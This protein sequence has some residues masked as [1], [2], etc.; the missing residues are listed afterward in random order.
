MNYSEKLKVVYQQLSLDQ[1]AVKYYSQRFY[2]ELLKSLAGEES[3]LK[4]APSFLGKPNGCETG[5]FMAID[6]GGSNIRVYLI[7]LL[8]SGKYQIIRNVSR[9]LKD[10]QGNYDYTSAAVHAPELF[11]FI[12]S[13]AAQIT[14]PDDE[15]CL[16]HTFSFPTKQQSVRDAE[17]LRWTKEIKTSGVNKPINS[18]LSESL[19]RNNLP[20]IKPVALINDTVATLLAQAYQNNN[21][22]IGSIC[23]TGHNTCYFESKLPE[24]QPMIINLESGNFNKLP[25]SVFDESLDKASDSPG[26]QRFEKMLSGKYIGEVLRIITQYIL[27]PADSIAGY[28]GVLEPYSLKAEHISAFLSDDSPDLN[29]IADILNTLGWDVSL[30]ERKLINHAA[31]LLIKRSTKLL[32]ASYSAIIN[33]IDPGLSKPH[34]IAVDGSLFR[35]M[36]GY[37]AQIEECLSLCPDNPARKATLGLTRDGSAVGAAVAAALARSQGIPPL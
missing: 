1:T 7:E 11:D 16:G 14:A 35:Y 9:P 37:M 12:S 28:K 13:M 32:A 10:P 8:G 23:G 22:N 3:S 26:A 24:I 30:E 34:L 2:K 31:S 20:G 4:I 19:K 25:F 18:L 17:L 15:Y 29:T 5:T 36:P 21:A 6:F 33:R 27:E